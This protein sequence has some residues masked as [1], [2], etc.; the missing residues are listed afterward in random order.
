MQG[1]LSLYSLA[2]PEFIASIQN[3]KAIGDYSVKSVYP[4]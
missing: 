4:D 1:V 3:I 2:P